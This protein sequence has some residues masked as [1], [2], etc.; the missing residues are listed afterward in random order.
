MCFQ[1]RNL[2]RDQKRTVGWEDGA[3]EPGGTECGHKP[4]STVLLP[5]LTGFGQ[6]E[7]TRAGRSSPAADPQPI[8]VPAQ[9][10]LHMDKDIPDRGDAR[11][12]LVFDG[13]GNV[14]GLAD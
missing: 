12:D 6:F 14:M 9:A 10:G 5:E 8:R 2:V 11:T 13:V 3:M 1:E 7:A 4:N